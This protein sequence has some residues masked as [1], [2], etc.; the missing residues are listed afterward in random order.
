[1]QYPNFVTTLSAEDISNKRYLLTFPKKMDEIFLRQKKISK[2]YV[3]KKPIL[4]TRRKKNPLKIYWQL[5]SLIHF[6]G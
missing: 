6:H 1:M 2:Y 3:C 4:A 5:I